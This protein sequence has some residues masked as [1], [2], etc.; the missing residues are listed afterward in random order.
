MDRRG[1]PVLVSSLCGFPVVFPDLS[2]HGCAAFP[3][4]SHRRLLVADSPTEKN[5]RLIGTA[6]RSPASAAA[7][8]AML[9]ADDRSVPDLPAE[10]LPLQD[11]SDDDYEVEMGPVVAVLTS[12]AT[13]SFISSMTFHLLMLGTVV[14]VSNLLGLS[15]L[16]LLDDPQPPLNAS[17]SDEDIEGELPKF[18]LVADLSIQ[19]EKPASSMEQLATQLQ[20]A[21]AAALQLANEEVWKSILGSDSAVLNE[22]GAGVL[23]K[24]PESGLAVTKGSFTAFTIPANP[25]PR[26]TYSIVIEIRLPDEFKRYEVRDLVGEVQGSDGYKQ[27]LPYDKDVPS[28]AGFPAENQRIRILNAST[29]LDVVKNRV[30]IVV[31]VPGAARLVKDVIRIRSKKLK[32]EQELTL[33]FGVPAPAT[34]S[35]KP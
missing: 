15:W 17:L 4:G 16:R 20:Q 27:K 25:N 24:V 19:T 10:T 28:A 8:G 34:S 33:V 9:V 21:D 23:L 29:V 35:G 30:Q 26:E 12:T 11:G 13:V 32:E 31:K 5:D 3:A 2:R 18:E 6:S 14:V 22:D 1:L 7:A